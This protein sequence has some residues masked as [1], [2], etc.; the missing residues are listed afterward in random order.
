MKTI[1]ADEQ[2]S[3]TDALTKATLELNKAKLDATEKY[4]KMQSQIDW[5]K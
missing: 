2:A 4:Q 5:S 1:K 3:I